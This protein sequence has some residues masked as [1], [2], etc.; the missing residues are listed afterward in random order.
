M[1]KCFIMEYLEFT[2][3]PYRG[4]G[5]TLEPNPPYRNST[6]EWATLEGRCT[7]YTCCAFSSTHSAANMRHTRQSYIS[8]NS[9]YLLRFW[10]YAYLL[11]LC[12]FKC[13]L[14]RTKCE[15]LNKW[16]FFSLIRKNRVVT[17][18]DTL[19]FP[20]ELPAEFGKYSATFLWILA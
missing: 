14:D 18:L 15:L 10:N 1:S 4:G 13:T 12:Q 20:T 6:Y 11:H 19:D 8:R 9:F 5:F 2:L 7:R 3:E 16:H 17:L